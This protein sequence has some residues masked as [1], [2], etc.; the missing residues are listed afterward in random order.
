MAA[1]QSSKIRIPRAGLGAKHTY[2]TLIS[3]E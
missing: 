1:V 3:S 2:E